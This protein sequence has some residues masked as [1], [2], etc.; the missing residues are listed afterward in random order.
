MVWGGQRQDEGHS[1]QVNER[2]CSLES[3]LLDA[4]WLELRIVITFGMLPMFARSRDEDFFWGSI[5]TPSS[6]KRTTS[7]KL[8][9]FAP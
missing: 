2:V 1:V 5:T 8:S 7:L 9:P 6:Q 3:A 4:K